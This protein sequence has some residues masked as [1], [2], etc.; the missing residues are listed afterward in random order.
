MTNLPDKVL[1]QTIC[2]SDVANIFGVIVY[3][4]AHAHL[5]KVL[6]D[7]D[8][9][10][11][12]DEL[13]GPKWP[14]FSIRAAQANASSPKFQYGSSGFMLPIWNEPSE[15]Q[16]LLELLE[17]DS[18]KNLPLLLLFNQ[19]ADGLVNQIR[20]PIDENNPEQTFNDLRKLF[21]KLADAIASIDPS[22]LRS[23]DGLYSA[24][25]LTVGHYRDT[26]MLKNGVRL[27]STLKSWL[28]D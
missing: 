1:R 6:K 2:R 22:C 9:W 26:K 5:I 8:Y 24:I 18:T 3:T 28:L 13:S 25:S 12:L 4:K 21:E 7:E 19:S 23:A 11:A 17:I 14:V 15:N 16:E 27:V 20:I 10:N